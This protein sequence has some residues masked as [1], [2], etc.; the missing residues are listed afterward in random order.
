MSLST[1]TPAPRWERRKADRPAELLAAALELFVEKGYAGTRLDDV[2][3]RAQVSKGTLYLYFANKEDLFKA[4]VRENVVALIRASAE[5]ASTHRGSSEG[6]LR[7][8]VDSWWQQFGNARAGG[9]SKLMVAESGNFPEIARFFV[10]EVIEPWHALM[11]SAIERGIAAGEFRRL[12]S[13]LFVRAMTA[14]LVMLSLWKHSLGACSRKPL[15]PER[16]LAT[17]LD[18]HLAAL[19]PAAAPLA[20]VTTAA[21]SSR[22]KPAMR[23]SARSRA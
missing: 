19:R 21:E 16:Y 11:A 13:A 3:A 9:I 23:R 17:V 4:V 2:A 14:P 8:L 5:R 20:K 12:D 1:D 7:T 15:D 10:E 22:R 6:L 18:I